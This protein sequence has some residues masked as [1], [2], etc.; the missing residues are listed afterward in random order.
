MPT[1]TE[2]GAELIAQE[3]RRQVFR[4]N[5]DAEHDDAHG[6]GSLLHAGILLACD[7]AGLELAGVDP[8]SPDGPWPDCLLLHA[9]AKYGDDDEVRLLTIA[10]AMIA[11]EIDRLNRAKERNRG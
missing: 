10:A 11:A 9:R 3:R 6:D 4:K 7:V 8:P 5:Y 2:P 1:E